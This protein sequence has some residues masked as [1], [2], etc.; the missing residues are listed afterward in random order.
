MIHKFFKQPAKAM[1]KNTTFCE[2]V[3]TQEFQEEAMRS[4]QN[5]LRDLLNQ[6]VEDGSLNEKDRKKKFKQVSK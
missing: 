1:T 4:S 6:I 2:R 5:A 3:T